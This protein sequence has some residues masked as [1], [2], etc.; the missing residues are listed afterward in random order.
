MNVFYFSSDLFA[1]VMAVS[2]ISLLENN[3]E[4]NDINIYIVDDGIS[5]VKKNQLTE[6]VNNYETIGHKRI[7]NYIDAPSPNDVLKYPFKSKYQMGHSYFR[8]CIGTLLPDSIKRVLCLDC[9]TLVCGNLEE[10]WNIPMKGN[11]L[12]GVSD[13]INVEKYKRQFKISKSDV[14]CNAGVFLVDLSEWRKQKIEDKIIERIAKQKGNVFFFEQTLMNCSCRGK[15]LRLPP[16]YNAYTLL[17][18]FQYRNL[19]K[20]RKPI[21]FFTEDQIEKAKTEPKIIHFTRNFYML[22]RPWLKGC[23][24]PMTD[25]YLRYKV[26]SPWKSL[27]EDNRSSKEIRRYSLWHSIPQGILATIANIIYNHIRPSMWWKNE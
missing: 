21:D 18:A 14:Y 15:I 26:I 12:A 8:M 16:E 27:D 25:E 11:I 19:I 5:I 1:S 13:C 4:F 6:M 24:H 22:S 2:I 7:I 23:D 10:L 9:D 3:R 17:W 20:W